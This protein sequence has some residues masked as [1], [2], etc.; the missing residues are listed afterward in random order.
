MRRHRSRLLLLAVV[1]AAALVPAAP[2]SAVD[3]D[4]QT[5]T[6]SEGI[7]WG[8][9][10]SLTA[11]AIDDAVSRSAEPYFER[12]YNSSYYLSDAT[13]QGCTFEDAGRELRYPT[14]RI[15]DLDV[16]G[17]VFIPSGS[18]A[19]QRGLLILHNPNAEPAALTPFFDNQTAFSSA[20]SDVVTTSDGDAVA[21]PA[22]DW[23]VMRNAA[24]AGDRRAAFLWQL[25]S[26]RRASVAEIYDYDD[27]ADMPPP[28]FT[29][30]TAPQ[31]RFDRVVVPPGGTATFLSLSLTRASD[32]DAESA[33]RQLQ[34]APDAVLTGLSDDEKRGLQNVGLPDADLDGVANGPDN[35]RFVANPDQANLDVDAQGDA[36]DDDVD[37]DG[38]TN[39]TEAARGT[40][41]RNTDTDGDGRLDDADACPLKGGLG[42]DGCARFD[43]P[44]LTPDTTKPG[45][46]IKGLKRSMKRRAFLRGVRCVVELSEAAGVTCR[47]LVRATRV[48]RAASAGDL[49]VA[50]RSLPL[51][52]G[53]R[54]T[55]LRPRRGL[56]RQ[57]RFRATL[58]VTATDAAGNRTVRTKRFRVR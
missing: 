22:D 33:A 41:P 26:E 28:P 45:V 35:C 12:D 27:R 20:D 31:A 54:S 16:S 10:S 46:A 9:Q 39:A 51:A 13:R 24:D 2:A 50:S 8:S 4:T 56:V 3:C 47:L 44:P 49:E 5:L 52:A 48:A 53:T 30:G 38:L 42:T 58:Q 29:G 55:K 7:E 23:V 14:V 25:G 11:Y 17:T 19:F 21:T 37:G 57:R 15:G 32:D 40:D 6:D 18:P 34:A 43:Q 1:A 36:C